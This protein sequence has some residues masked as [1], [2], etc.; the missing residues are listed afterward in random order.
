MQILM[1]GGTGW[2]GGETVREALRRGHEVTC[3]ARG[4]RPA[5]EGAR[6]V[7]ADRDDP[8]P[9]APVAGRTWDAVLDVTDQP[10]RVREAVRSLRAGHW[11]YVSSAS[12][13][14]EGREVDRSEDAPVVD[15]LDGDRY[16][17]MEDYGAAKRA[18]EHAV[19]G[20]PAPAAVV[21]AGLIGGPGDGSGRSGYWPWRFAHPSGPDVLVPDD[22]DLPTALIDVR[23]LARWLVGVVENRT[24]GV[25]NATGPTTTLG[26]VLEAAEQVAGG[27]AP[28]RPVDPARLLELGVAPWAGPCS[29]PLWLPM[30]ELRGFATLDT[31]RA[32]A[33][34][35]TT[36]PVADTLRDV[37]AWEVTGRT[38]PRGAGLSDEDEQRVRAR[39][40]GPV[41]A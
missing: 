22:P 25:L 27:P 39:L 33:E 23:D 35:L 2:L 28:A 15:P 4:T 8:Q 14:A 3:L 38:R 24:E 16:E 12:V 26:A 31:S 29:L 19:L 41:D 17:D 6:L 36:R 30:P 18:C 32:R 37:L 11:V 34:G 5:P 10:G 1:L 7:R 40:D 21:R 13:Y 9:L 20:A